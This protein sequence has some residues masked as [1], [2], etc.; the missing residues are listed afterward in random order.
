[1]NCL[2][3]FFCKIE[4]FYWEIGLFLCVVFFMFLYGVGLLFDM[5]LKRVGFIDV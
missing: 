4:L 3:Y 5:Y 2:I 1:M